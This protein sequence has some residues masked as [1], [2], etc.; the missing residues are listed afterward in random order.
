[1]AATRSPRRSNRVKPM[2]GRKTDQAEYYDDTA[3]NEKCYRKPKSNRKSPSRVTSTKGADGKV[4]RTKGVV[5]RDPDGKPFPSIYEVVL[6]LKSTSDKIDKTDHELEDFVCLQQRVAATAKS[7]PNIYKALIRFW[8]QEVL[9]LHKDILIINGAFHD[10]EMI[11]KGNSL[12]FS[13]PG[14]KNG[15]ISRKNLQGLTATYAMVLKTWTN[16]VQSTVMKSRQ[17][18][19]QTIAFNGQN[20]LKKVNKDVVRL[21]KSILG[22]NNYDQLSDHF[23]DDGFIA[24][25]TLKSIFYIYLKQDF[26][27]RVDG[28][29]AE[30]GVIG[31]NEAGEQVIDTGVNL[32]DLSNDELR[33]AAIKVHGASFM[34]DN[35]TQG[36]AEFLE[37]AENLAGVHDDIRVL[38]DK[39]KTAGFVPMLEF[40][41][42]MVAKLGTSGGEE[43]EELMRLLADYGR[44]SGAVDDDE[45]KEMA[46]ALLNDGY[47]IEQIKGNTT[48]EI[49]SLRGSKEF[50]VLMRALNE[51]DDFKELKEEIRPPPLD[52]K[53]VQRKKED[54]A[55]KRILSP[56]SMGKRMSPLR[57]RQIISG[58]RTSPRRR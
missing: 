30:L 10:T 58:K 47:F 3:P 18:K 6:R 29:I 31:V 51:V 46:Q 2:V 13:V 53:T 23:K 32:N 44:N 55:S 43:D 19:A 48:E 42:K 54:E 22:E 34:F 28:L 35:E 21:V 52:R 16:L 9:G 27:N 49:V 25:D 12:S 20:K 11:P 15:K 26:I 5:I 14:L 56:A 4:E 38:V 36:G 45:I 1:M 50:K 24:G 41:S 7:S 37:L 40:V 57:Q 17:P 33:D 39:N 8:E